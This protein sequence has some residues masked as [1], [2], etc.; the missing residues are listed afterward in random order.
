MDYLSVFD[1]SASGLS[2]EKSRLE[3]V[4]SN[5]ANANSTRPADQRPY[6][7]KRLMTNPAGAKSFAEQMNLVDELRGVGSGKVY[8]SND[9]FRL[10]YEP[11][12]PN[13][14]EKGFVKYANV[15]LLTEMMTMLR[16]QRAYEANVK[17]VNAYKAMIQ[18]ALKIGS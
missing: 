11:D 5:L 17:A 18:Q 2:V 15:N 4:A 12:N 8:E 13:S 16:S 10:S 3:L 14:D 9:D 7:A 6:A 1:I